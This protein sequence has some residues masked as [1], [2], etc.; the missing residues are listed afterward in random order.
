MSSAVTIVVKCFYND[1]VSSLKEKSKAGIHVVLF[2]P[3][4]AVE[5]VV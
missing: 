1:Q 3:P 2:T 5:M 4:V